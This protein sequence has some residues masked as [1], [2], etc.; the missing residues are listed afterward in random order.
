MPKRRKF[1]IGLGSMAAGTAGVFGTAATTTINVNDRGVSANIVS[2]S[3]GIIA[4]IDKTPE[5]EIVSYADDSDL[6]PSSG[7]T[8]SELEID[9]GN[10]IRG[11]TDSTGVNVGSVVEVGNVADPEPDGDPAFSLRNQAAGTIDSYE[12]TFEP[13]GS[14]S[15]PSGGSELVLS[16]VQNS[17]GINTT[18]IGG[19]G[20]DPTGGVTLLSGT[21]WKPAQ[22]IFGAVKVNADRPDS[23]TSDD[24]SGVLN[25][26]GTQDGSDN[27]S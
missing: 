14:F 25:I 17:F 6:D 2:D 10:D 24:L 13:T 12:I 1:L 15:S 18:T 16:F 27:L 19:S 8:S 22:R 3:D 4:L 20:V 9:F 21:D 23:S 7:P 5:N 26:S 11:A